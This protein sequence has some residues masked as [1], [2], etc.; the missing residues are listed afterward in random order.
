MK[1]Y[2]YL[3]IGASM[4]ADAAVRGIRKLD[5]KGTIGLIGDE[6]DA[7][8]ARP[9]LSKGLWGKKSVE[10]IMCDT[11]QF[12]VDLHLRR[13]AVKLETAARKVTD[14]QGETYGYEKLLFANGGAPRHLPFGGDDIIYYRTLADYRQLRTLADEGKSFAVIGGGFIGSEIAAALAKQG[15]KVH[16]LFPEDG[17]CAR[18]FPADLA[19]FLVDYYT[20]N[21]IDVHP[22]TEVT[23]VETR[24]GR[25]L[26][27]TGGGDEFTV[28]AVVAGIGMIPNTDLAKNAGLEVDNGIVVDENLR[29]SHE[30]IFAAGDVACYYDKTLEK[31]RRVEH[32]DNAVT[33]GQAAGRAMAGDNTPYEHTPYFYSDL[34][35]LGYEAIGEMNPEMEIVADWESLFQKGVVYY[36]DDG[37]VR[38]VL[39]WDNWGQTNAALQLIAESGPFDEETLKGRLPK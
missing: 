6:A 11:E 16:L 37:R 31:R 5:R 21:G 29:T 3:I 8:Y 9:P 39:L 33:M 4:T 38:G 15:C 35:D 27:T 34:F 2:T 12:D 10:D 17:I 30:D 1:N 7:P 23:N 13:R 32:E 19:G 22:S 14:D 20:E 25:K 18:L 28:D 36:L 26:V 24:Q